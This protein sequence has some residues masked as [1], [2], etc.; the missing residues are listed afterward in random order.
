[1]R[2][3]HVWQGLKL[4]SGQRSESMRHPGDGGRPVAS[5]PWMVYGRDDRGQLLERHV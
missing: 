5:T 4:A 3:S 1:V 2:P